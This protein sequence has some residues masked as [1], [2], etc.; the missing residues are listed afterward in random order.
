VRGAE[1]ARTRG[2]YPGQ[3]AADRLSYDDVCAFGHTCHRRCVRE[4]APALSIGV[5]HRPASA[6]NRYRHGHSRCNHQREWRVGVDVQSDGGA[7]GNQRHG[8][9]R[10]WRLDQKQHPRRQSR[11]PAARSAGPL[12]CGWGRR[13]ADHDFAGS[14]ERCPALSRGVRVTALPHSVIA[15]HA[16]PS[17]S[18]TRTSSLRLRCRRH[19][20]SACTCQPTKSCMP[21]ATVPP[22]RS[23]RLCRSRGTRRG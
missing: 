12:P 16:W 7:G 21:S 17:R 6:T 10:Y 22:L 8:E 15:R 23:L 13:A 14:P 1:A 11:R 3:A 19:E 20:R 4:P 9:S 2:W 5:R 18:L